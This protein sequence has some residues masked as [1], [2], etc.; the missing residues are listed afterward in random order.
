MAGAARAESEWT[1]LQG[2]KAGGLGAYAE[3]AVPAARPEYVEAGPAAGKGVSSQAWTAAVKKEYERLTEDGLG[4]IAELP[5]A[6]VSELPD[7][8]KKQLKKDKADYP[9]SPSAAYKM[10]VQGKLAF[11]I[12]N[13]NEGGMFVNIFD[14]SGRKVAS[15]GCFESGSFAWAGAGK[16]AA[17]ALEKSS[18]YTAWIEAVKRAYL[19]NGVA[20]LRRAAVSELPAAA[21]RQLE[22]EFAPSENISAAYVLRL[23]GRSAYIV[24]SECG[25]GTR[26]TIFDGRGNR[27]VIVGTSGPAD[28]WG[29]DGEQAPS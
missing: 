4:A 28:S 7:A 18:S 14:E 29:P 3:A 6:K 26:A 10:K 27:I 19:E 15:G 9:D 21:V 20:S 17:P 23:R 22:K 8:A 12:Q 11:V 2:L 5:G 24:Q 1:G 13:E 25:A 16:A